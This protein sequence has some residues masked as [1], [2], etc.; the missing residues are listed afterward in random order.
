[1]SFRILSLAILLAAVRVTPA[2]AQLSEAARGGDPREIAEAQWVVFDTTSSRGV[3]SLSTHGVLDADGVRYIW[4]RV[5]RPMEPERTY[6]FH[7]RMAFDCRRR[8][9]GVIRMVGVD[10]GEVVSDERGWEPVL[11]P[12]PREP[13]QRRLIAHVCAMP[14]T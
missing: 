5:S 14:G 13:Q 12:G 1:M 6:L 11:E 2:M 3:R 10:K 7:A 4:L 9:E 8:I